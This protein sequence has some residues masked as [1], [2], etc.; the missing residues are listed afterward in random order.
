MLSEKQLKQSLQESEE[1]FRLA[2][3][4]AN[5]GMCLV[6]LQ[7]NLLQ[8]NAKMTEIF[9]YSQTELETMTVNDLSLPEDK[10][11][12]ITFIKG[13]IAQVQENTVFEKRYYH[14]IG[15]IIYAEVSSSLV[16][17]SQG[18]PLYFISHVR[19]ITQ[20]KHYEEELKQSRDTIAKINTELEERVIQRTAELQKRERLLRYYFD[21][22]LIGMA[23]TSIDKKWL[24]VNDRLCEILGYSL[25]ELQSITWEEITYPDDLEI[26]LEKFNQVLAGKIDAYLIDKRFIHKNGNIIYTNLAV[27]CHRKTDGSL[28]FFVVFLK[29]ISERKEAELRL[30]Q[31]NQ[32]LIKANRL[33]DEFLAM[34]SHELRTPLNA[35]LGMTEIL[36]EEIYG[37]INTQQEKSLETIE[38]SGKHLLSLIN[39]ILD[40]AKIE[41]GKVT[42]NLQNVAVNSLCESSL[43][44]INPLAQKKQIQLKM[45]LPFDLPKINVDENRI[46][47][48]LLNLLNNAVKFTPDYG[49]ITLEVIYPSL[50][51]DQSSNHLRFAVKDT[52]IGIASE[53][54]EKLFKPFVQIDGALSRQYEG[55]GL[56]LVLVKKI[57]ELH[58][59]KVEISSEV[60]VGSCFTVDL[61]I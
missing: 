15:Y 34:M 18:N 59:G 13:A 40:V 16:K 22:P 17:D 43:T 44:L 57:V 56:G 52:G 41:A 45:V 46:R 32:E 33:K 35:I 58:G 23:M 6:D 60:G 2:F 3:D 19:D 21:Q 39:D 30:K 5:I 37:E 53:D 7:G 49:Q 9:G 14:K 27:Q 10:Q 55:T 47:Q 31:L 61:P 11:V 20:R 51:A 26:D 54:K 4:Y 12:S 1:K 28:D 8:V 42:F 24:D 48:V 50:S 38:I 36:Q 29:D 25:Q